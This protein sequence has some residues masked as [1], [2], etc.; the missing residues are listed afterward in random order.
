MLFSDNL[1]YNSLK[2]KTIDL[3]KIEMISKTI[4]SYRLNCKCLLIMDNTGAKLISKFITLSEVIN[5]GIFSIESIYKK[6]KPYKTY[7]AIYLISSAESSINLVLED[8]KS[9]KKR[10]YKWCHLFILDKITNNIYDLL[11]KKTFIRRIQTFK[12]LI[13]NYMPLDKNLFFFGLK[14]NFNSIYQL[15]ANDEQNKI[16]NKINLSKICSVCRVSGTYPNIVYFIHDPICKYLADKI[17]KKIKKYFNKNGIQKNGILLLTS[18]KLDIVGPIQFDLTYGHLLMELYKNL[19]KSEKNKA[20]INLNG[21]EEDI[22]FDHE[23][24]LYNKY[25]VLSLY[26][27]MTT[28]NN[29]IEKFMKSDMAKLE[30][31]DDL[32]SLEDMG[33]AMKNI[34]EYKYLNPLYNKHLKIVEDMNK[35]CLQR[36]IMKIIDLQSTI[37]AGANYKGKKKGA[38]HISKR[39]LEN[40]ND[41]NKED[42]LRLLC[43]IKYYNPESDIKSLIDIIE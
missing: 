6:R 18:R 25:K 11:L 22:I 9:E 31:M 40:K 13:M 14:G 38:H 43:I 4:N 42:F 27:I 21:K 35:K 23:D 3:F 1:P 26:Q 29:D 30:K 41:F 34:T 19:E 12:E 16:L 37:I 36:N 8:F 24:A 20:K 32:N 10:L 15:F 5:Q 28:L 39:I 33:T 17:N 2:K 7:G